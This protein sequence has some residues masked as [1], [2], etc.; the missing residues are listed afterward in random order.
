MLAAAPGEPKRVSGGMV[1]SGTDSKFRF[2]EGLGRVEGEKIHSKMAWILARWKS[3]VMIV[4]LVRC[5]E[6]V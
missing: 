1:G 6:S 2:V 3:E 4:R 5:W